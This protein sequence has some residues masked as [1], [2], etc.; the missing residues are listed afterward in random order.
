MKETGTKRV[1]KEIL[2]EII[3]YNR[4]RVKTVAKGLFT[5]YLSL[6]LLSLD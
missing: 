5:P 6:Y 4:E 2:F 3:R 1:H